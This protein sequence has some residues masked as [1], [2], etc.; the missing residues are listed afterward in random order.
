MLLS[1]GEHVCRIAQCVPGMSFHVGKTIRPEMFAFAIQDAQLDSDWLGYDA[2]ESAR[3]ET[4]PRTGRP[5]LRT[6]NGNEYYDILTLPA[7]EYVPFA[8]LEKALAFAAAGGVVAGYGIRPCNTPTRGKT[9]EDVNR[10]VAD[11][12]AQPTALFIEG[13]PTGAQLRAAFAQ[14]YPGTDQPLAVRELDFVDLS[15]EDGRMLALNHYEKNGDTVYFIANQDAARRRDLTVC[16]NVA[17]GQAELWDPMQGTVERPVIENGLIKLALE[18]SQAVFLVWPK[19]PRT[20]LPVRME[21]P[22][23]EMIALATEENVT[24]VVIDAEENSVLLSLEGAKWIWHPVNPRA[25]G[26]VMFRASIDVSSAVEAQLIFACDNSAEV[27]VNGEKVAEQK[28][29]GA[30]DYP[31]WRT[32]TRATVTLNSGHNAI[33]VKAANPIPGY[34]GFI[35]AFTWPGG[36]F[37]TDAANWEVSRDNGAYVNAG[38][39][40]AYGGSP[41][42]RFVDAGDRDYVLLSLEGAKWIWH[43]VNPQAEG[44]VMFRASVDVPSAV[45]AQL[46]FSCDNAAEVFVNG[47]KVAEQKDGGAPNYPGWRTPTRAKIA[48]NSGHNAISVKAANPIPGYAGFVAAF[49]WPGGALRTDVANWEVSRDDGAFVKAGEVCTYGGSPWGRI[50]DKQQITFSTFA[51]SVATDCTFTLPAVKQG[52]RVYLVC[53]DVAG[54]KSAAVTVNGA[55]AG[56]FIDAPYRLDITKSV[57]TGENTLQMKPFRVTNPKIVMITN[58]TIM[59]V[60]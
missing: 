24:P 51:E 14:P 34:A 52:E 15:A 29:G 56:G 6:I 17:V 13:E 20:A 5:S 12:F 30:P 28:D 46:I 7:T 21:R 37:K 18:P 26:E 2:V 10:L 25:E 39:I 49:T 1:E 41:W 44:E 43:P 50:G 11:I 36:A 35:A 16:A 42:G 40:C 57:K 31:G 4:N 47:Q 32:P 23:G 53:D 48:L 38:E 22:S 60:R 58:S 3:I 9:S 59:I 19:N 55:F 45:E 27:F 54:E 33:S 8:T